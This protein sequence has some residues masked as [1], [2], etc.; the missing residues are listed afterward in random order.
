M[1]S[2]R[3]ASKKFFRSPYFFLAALLFLP[4]VH[5]LPAAAATP[6]DEFQQFDKELNDLDS[7]I[8]EHLKRAREAAF[9]SQEHTV[10]APGQSVEVAPGSSAVATP[11]PSATAPVP[12]SV[13]TPAASSNILGDSTRPVSEANPSSPS[14]SAPKSSGYAAYS[15]PAAS[16]SSAPAAPAAQPVVTTPAAKPA[17]AAPAIQPA[18]VRGPDPRQ[19][20]AQNAADSKA[21]RESELASRTRVSGSYRA[22]AGVG[23]NRTFSI[24]DSN[25]DLQDRDYHYLFGERR[26]DTFDPG[27]YSQYRLDIDSQ[28][29]KTD[30]VFVQM[31]ADPWSYTGQ[32]SEITVFNADRSDHF[33]AKQKYWGPNNSTVPYS[34]RSMKGNAIGFP[35]LE[36]ENG[37]TQ[38]F[39]TRGYTDYGTTY[40]V[41]AQDIDYEF[42]PLR[43]AWWDHEGDIWHVRLF[44]LADQ[45]Q[46]MT[47]DDPMQLSNRKDFWQGS[48]WL[49]EWIPLQQFTIS[50]F[51]PTRSHL[52][53]PVISRGRYSDEEAF[54]ARDSAGNYLT[55]LRGGA[56]EADFGRTYIGSMIASKYGPWDEYQE[57]DNI[58]GV[59]RIKHQLT[60]P[61]M[62]GATYTYRAGLI[63]RE[64]D[65][66]N[67]VISMDTKYFTNETD[68]VYG[69]MAGSR[70]DVDRLSSF[71]TAYEGQ[72][73]KA[74]FVKQAGDAQKGVSR[75]NGDFSWIGTKFTE[76]LSRYASLRDDEFW[77][78][79]ITWA[80]IPPDVDPFK[81]GTGEDYG[82]YVLRLNVLSSFEDKGVDNLFD[83]RHVRATDSNGY[84]HV[85]N[86]DDDSFIETVIRDETSWKFAP[87]W[88]AKNFMRF[89]IL[90]KTLKGIEP[91]LSGYNA[92]QL[93]DPALEGGI[94]YE[95]L[96][97]QPGLDANRRSFGQGLQ[98]EPTHQWT[99]DGTFEISND[100]PDF[101]RG[102][103]NDIYPQSTF[104]DPYTQNW[105]LYRQQSFLYRQDVFGLPSYDYF[106][107]M[108]QRVAYRYSENLQFIFHSAQNSYT[109]WAPIDDNV[110]HQ[111]LSVDWQITDRW[112]AFFDYTHSRLMD[113]PKLISTGF[114]TLDRDSHH[115]IYS[116]LKYRINSSTVLTMEYGVFGQTF[117]EGSEA[118][119]ASAY[120][121]T[122]FS[123]PTVDTE[124]LFRVSLDGEF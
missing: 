23:R 121:V 95:N 70:N 36:A 41:P 51:T 77:G 61:W 44:A 98:W 96:M 39:R 80:K 57:F 68:Y 90:P 56:L 92:P 40:D 71:Q 109:F 119:P 81:L 17:T 76:T 19:V 85:G 105:A 73:Y 30:S 114:R 108:K 107:I 3:P 122:T 13:A 29:T 50:G 124:H 93:Q 78:T 55:L 75:I 123:L 10:A 66:Y 42:R 49:D 116:R 89:H 43:K 37:M 86:D 74:G 22:A 26:Y 112:S 82:R 118:F 12:A 47:T 16:T 97:I 48:A 62:L 25:S 111:G 24:N 65:A 72:A 18:A 99:L 106:T 91:F 100:I 34:V 33:T 32:T 104:I 103:L 35:E 115:N 110:A 5:A 64:P 46:V 52:R 38:P 101:P 87:N 6:S 54:I 20:L 60:E 11:V 45:N 59:L 9:W 58:P 14:F 79:H 7:K 94:Y 83:F 69:Q 84:K 53:R 27:I 21:A 2:H 15:A 67:Q 113:I 28:V 8:Q 120:A 1:N 63:D 117:Y 88:T 31:V 4:A 102:L